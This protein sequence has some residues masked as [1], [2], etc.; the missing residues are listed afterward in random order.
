MRVAYRLGNK[1]LPEYASR[2][3]RKDF[4]LPQIF[5]C[6]ALRQFYNLSY[7]RTEALLRD[8]R[9]LRRVVKLKRAPDHN[10]L[11]DAFDA[12]AKLDTFAPMLDELATAFESAGLLKLD[13]KPLAI[14]SSHY[15][16]RHVSRH[17]ERRKRKS[18]EKS[19]AS[20]IAADARR[21]ATNKQLPKLAVAVA[22]ACHL[23][24]SVW[25]GTGVGPDHGHFETLAYHAWRRAP[26]ETI[27]GDAGYDSEGAHCLVRDDMSCASLIPPTAGRTTDKPPTAHYRRLMTQLLA[28]GTPEREQ[29]GQRWQAETVN[30]MMKRNYGSA[31]RART[32]ERRERELLLKA[33][34][35]NIAL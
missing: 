17:F 9:E 24:L 34:V 8:T 11:C 26:V 32:P 18:E 21:S 29:Y 12:L 30:S 7:R 6:L 23:V 33:M 25:S 2:F 10:T 22:C 19:D 14:D 35:H 3:S 16:S 1:H 15:E 4:T 28:E 20:K 31:L 13:D 27:V 5:A